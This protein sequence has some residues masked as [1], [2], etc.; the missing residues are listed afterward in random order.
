MS[1]DSVIF[2][3]FA[4]AEELPLYY[5]M[6]DIF[7]TCSLWETFNR[8]LAEAQACGKPVIAFNIGPHPEVIDENGMLVETGNVEKFAEAC[9]TK[10]RLRQDV[11]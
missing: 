7:A 3:G 8:P 11:R 1:D 2:T 6:C 9:V 10:L 5:A 4:P